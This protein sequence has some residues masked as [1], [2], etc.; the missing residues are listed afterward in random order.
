MFKKLFLLFCV[1]GIFGLHNVSFSMQKQKKQKSASKKVIKFENIPYELIYNM[2]FVAAESQGDFHLKRDT[3]YYL[4]DAKNEDNQEKKSAQ[5]CTQESSLNCTEYSVFDS[6]YKFEMNFT[7]KDLLFDGPNHKNYFLLGS[8]I[9]RMTKKDKSREYNSYAFGL[10]K[11]DPKLKNEIMI[12]PYKSARLEGTLTALALSKKN[13]TRAAIADHKEL[14]ILNVKEFMTSSG[15]KIRL[16]KIGSIVVPENIYFTKLN[17]LT[18]NILIG[19]TSTKKIYRIVVDLAEK[20]LEMHEL[21]FKNQ[22]KKRLRIKDFVVDEGNTRQI[23]LSTTNKQLILWDL[24]LSTLHGKS[25][26]TNSKKSLLSLLKD[27]EVNDLEFHNGRLSFTTNQDGNEIRK[28]Y[29]LYHY[30]VKDLNDEELI[31]AK[32][33]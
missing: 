25:Q 24:S 22:K 14:S 4:C 19:L 5:I 26:K 21:K 16:D 10:V 33:P 11:H 17:F 13:P 1:F 23:I 30:D 3:I 15:K 29:Q 27:V 31:T 20:K 28:T 7:A 6:S 12:R 32:I 18:T 2:C 8:N 9:E